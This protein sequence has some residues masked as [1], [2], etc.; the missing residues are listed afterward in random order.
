MQYA[1]SEM[2]MKDKDT[3]VKLM[4]E[5]CFK[6]FFIPL[7]FS[8]TGMAWQVCHVIIIIIIIILMV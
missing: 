6:I 5:L 3:K 2:K 7:R 1:H 4:K 8:H